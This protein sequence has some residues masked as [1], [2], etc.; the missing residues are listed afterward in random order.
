MKWKERNFEK[1]FEKRLI[2]NLKNLVIVN[3]RKNIY[4]RPRIRI[5]EYT[6]L[7]FSFS[8]EYGHNLA[9]INVCYETLR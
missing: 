7:S 5:S 3:V 2:E 9:E 4:K 1:T 6:S 8:K